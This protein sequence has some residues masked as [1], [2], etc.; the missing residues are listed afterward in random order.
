MNPVIRK[1]HEAQLRKDSPSSARVTPCALTCAC[2]K[3]K[4]R[5]EGAPQAFGV[6]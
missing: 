2:R 5:G 6:W 4:A 3:A 1:L